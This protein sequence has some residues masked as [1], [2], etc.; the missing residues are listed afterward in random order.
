M[1]AI[2]FNPGKSPYMT[3]SGLG[4]GLGGVTMQTSENKNKAEEES[5][6]VTSQGGPASEQ[7]SNAQSNVDLPQASYMDILRISWG[8]WYRFH[9]LLYLQL[10]G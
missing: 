4:D 7:F 3:V 10:N 9:I 6:L 5:P 1:R 2:P 8:I